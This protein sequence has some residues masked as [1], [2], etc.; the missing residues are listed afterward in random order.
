MAFGHSFT[1]SVQLVDAGIRL[2]WPR[3]WQISGSDP[4][5]MPVQAADSTPP[6]R[7]VAHSVVE[8]AGEIM[9]KARRLRMIF[10]SFVAS[11][12]P[13]QIVAGG[14]GVR[15]V[16]LKTRSVSARVCLYSAWHDHLRH[17][18]LGKGR[19]PVGRPGGLGQHLGLSRPL[20]SECP[21]TIVPKK[22]H[23]HESTTKRH[24]HVSVLRYRGVDPPS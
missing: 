7:P 6:L 15:V 19:G 20:R 21:R 4:R 17:S 23:G 5:W 12:A 13:A 10:Q 18:R 14:E 24:H 1:P 9:T 11:I 3:L 8:F 16:R 22:G 2:G